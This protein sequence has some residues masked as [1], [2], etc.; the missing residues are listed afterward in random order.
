MSQTLLPPA[1]LI[2]AAK[3]SAQ[4]GELENPR[5]NRLPHS[6][7]PPPD[8][9]ESIISKLEQRP[10]APAE[11]SEMRSCGRQVAHQRRGLLDAAAFIPGAC[12]QHQ[13]QEEPHLILKAPGLER[14]NGLVLQIGVVLSELV[15]LSE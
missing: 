15:L 13:D 12:A 5:L 10:R 1:K 3:I 14:R 4:Y 2:F 6:T 9:A 7:P 11:P 8:L